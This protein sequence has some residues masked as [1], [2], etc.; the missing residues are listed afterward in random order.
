[1]VPEHLEKDA[2][3]VCVCVCVFYRFKYL[4]SLSFQLIYCFAGTVY[5]LLFFLISKSDGVFNRAKAGGISLSVQLQYIYSLFDVA[6]K[7][8]L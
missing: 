5:G 8:C 1:M 7:A 4:T 6:E 3:Y 2:K